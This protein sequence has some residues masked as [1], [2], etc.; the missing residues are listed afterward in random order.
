MTDTVL[1]LSKIV[2]DTDEQGDPIVI[3]EDGEPHFFRARDA[4]SLRERAQLDGWIKRHDRLAEKE[5]PSEAD[6]KA[7]KQLQVDICAFVLPT[8]AAAVFEGLEPG[9]RS[10][11]I[12]AFLV[13]SG[14]A[15]SIGKVA[16]S[17]GQKIGALASPGSNGSTG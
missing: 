4:M 9:Q 16:L 10:A 5:T 11:L 8:C 14:M 12:V 2:S 3:D 17:R 6:E 15:S 7:H 1:D 13:D